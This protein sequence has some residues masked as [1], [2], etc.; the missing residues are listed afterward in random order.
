MSKKITIADLLANKDKL[1]KKTAAKAQL[2][3][4]S[5]GGQITVQEPSR[6]LCTEVFEMAENPET[7]GMSDVHMAYNCVVEPNLKDSE[8][9]KAYGCVQ[10]TDI[11]DELF[12]AGEVAAI[13]TFCI[14]MA[15]YGTGLKKV[16]EE[17]KNS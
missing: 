16:D 13:S 10:P 2:F 4:E 11:V 6:D 1:K 7:R 12:K 9:Q 15:G 5:L 14:G 3:I 17:I 8:L